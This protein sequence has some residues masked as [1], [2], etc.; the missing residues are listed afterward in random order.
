MMERKNRPPR[1]HIERRASLPWHL[2]LAI[3]LLSILAAF[4]FCAILTMVITGVRPAEFL[5]TIVYGSFGTLHLAGGHPLVPDE[6][7]ERRR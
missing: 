3:R 1:F 4:I 5:S 6:I 7:L 2:S